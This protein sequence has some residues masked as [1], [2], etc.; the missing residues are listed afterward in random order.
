M[1]HR[2]SLYLALLGGL[3][4]CQPKPSVEVVG[5]IYYETW[6]FVGRDD[7]QAPLLA[8]LSIRKSQQSKKKVELESKL[9]MSREGQ[10]RQIFREKKSVEGNLREVSSTDPISLR[11]QLCDGET[12]LRAEVSRDFSLQLQSGPLPSLSAHAWHDSRI[13]DGI[14]TATLTLNQEKARGCLFVERGVSLGKAPEPFFGDF[15]WVALLDDK[16]DCWL[17]S[18]GTRVGGF[19]LS[20][21][22]A[23]SDE[24]AR[25]SAALVLD[26]KS[27]QQVPTSWSLRA[28]GLSFSAE[29]AAVSG[30]RG[31][32]KKLPSGKS[33][34]YGHG[35]VEG[36]V[37]VK[38]EPRQCIGWV[39]HIK[40]E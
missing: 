18:D 33:V 23:V 22:G 10:T 13:G 19:A 11:E 8:S 28:P 24:V 20:G 26:K 12:C 7:Q 21:G 30:H 25:K 27:G 38:G 15:D 14:T 40:D 17:V 34:F 9:M 16:G 35:A 6:V 5:A 37:Q 39:Q 36:S 1:W 4:S 31:A 32:G 3:F 2:A 29:V